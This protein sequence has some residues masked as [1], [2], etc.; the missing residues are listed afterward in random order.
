MA[1]KRLPSSSAGYRRQKNIPGP[2]ASSGEESAN[3]PC[4]NYPE[5]NKGNGSDSKKE[6]IRSEDSD[7]DRIIKDNI[8]KESE[9]RE[10]EANQG[11]DENSDGKDSDSEPEYRNSRYAGFL[12]RGKAFRRE[13]HSH[14]KSAKK[15]LKNAN[16]SLSMASNKAV[17]SFAGNAGNNSPTKE[18]EKYQTANDTNKPRQAKPV[19][20]SCQ[21][22]YTEA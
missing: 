1:R 18:K 22:H 14:I 6:D 10:R 20:L 5:E 15:S 21:Q 2:E 9:D 3:N 13:R 16:L 12:N 11:K 8:D 4:D 19:V 7:S 17:G